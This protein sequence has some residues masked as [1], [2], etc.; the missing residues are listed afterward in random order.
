MIKKIKKYFHLLFFVTV[1]YP[2]EFNSSILLD[3]AITDLYNYEFKTSKIKLNSIQ[4]NDPLNPISPFLN[5][6]VEWLYNQT[7]YGYEESYEAIINGVNN[8]IPIYKKLINQYPENAQ[9]NLYLG[10]SYGL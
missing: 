7:Q 6:V 9:Y 10:S 4:K 3:Q 8:T 1:I 2:N 5:I